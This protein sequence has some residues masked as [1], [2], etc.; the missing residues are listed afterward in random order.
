MKMS[1]FDFSAENRL[2]QRSSYRYIFPPMIGM[3]FAQSAPLVDCICVSGTLGEEA[4]SAIATV[5]PL[6]YFLNIIAALGGIGCGVVISRCSGS[7]EK[8]K[9]ARAFT[10]SLLMLILVTVILSILTGIFIDPV[11]R[12][13]SATPENY[14]YAR[15]YI[16]VSLAGTVFMVLNFAGDYILANDNNENLAMA[17]DITG[18]VV[19]MVIDY[20]GLYVLHLGIRAAAFGTVFGSFCCCLVYML[21]FRKKDRLCRIVSPKKKPGDPGLLEI[22][23][24][25]SPEA[26]MYCMIGLQLIVQ[27]FVLSED[28]GTSGLGNSAVIE[29][30]MLLLTIIIAGISDAIYPMAAAYQGEGNRSGMLI[31]KRTLLRTGMIILSIPVILLIALPELVIIP[32]GIS[33]PVMLSTLPYA[34]RIVCFTHILVFI[35]TTLIDYLSATEQELQANLALIIQNAVEIPLILLL[36]RWSGMNSPLYA[37]LLAQIAVL[38]YLFGFCDNLSGGIKEYRQENLLLLLGGRLGPAF[39]DEIEAASGEILTNEQLSLIREKMLKPLLKSIPE[40]AS[41]ECTYTI[42]KRE[43]E[44]AAAILRYESKKDYLGAEPGMSEIDFGDQETEVQIPF[45]T[46]IRSEFL[47]M[48]RMMIVFNI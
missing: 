40:G 43:D 20:V 41:P 4:L 29:N 46:C 34:I 22:F 5:S 18:A 31:T 35:N 19:N 28:G 2:V 24:P 23:K 7:G 30:L 12:Y 39:Q 27:N 36:N 9:A 1:G 21:H 8:E 17:G 10:R 47:G 3:I 13:L 6:A 44:R 38:V 26:L 16:L 45:D 15:E 32:Y 33:D 48:R 25:G 14:G 42:L 37:S 11:L